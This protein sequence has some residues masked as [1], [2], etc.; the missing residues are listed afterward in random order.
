MEIAK[1]VA[2]K[3][4]DDHQ[5]LVG[6]DFTGPF[7]AEASVAQVVGGDVAEESAVV[8]EDIDD[9]VRQRLVVRHPIPQRVVF[10]VPPLELRA[11]IINWGHGSSL[12]LRR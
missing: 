4:V 7:G 3:L 10:E 5:G 1:V 9:A 2:A 11:R 6:D 12:E 8:I